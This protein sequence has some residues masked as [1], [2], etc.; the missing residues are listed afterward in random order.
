MA[1]KSVRIIISM[2][3][4]I[5]VE[6]VLGVLGRLLGECVQCVVVQVAEVADGALAP[7]RT[8]A[9]VLGWLLRVVGLL[10]VP[11]VIDGHVDEERTKDATV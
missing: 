1:P 6:V 4:E 5:D 7:R 11:A 8:R 2:L 3:T 10:V 9:G